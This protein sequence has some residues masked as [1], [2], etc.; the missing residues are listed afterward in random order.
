MYHVF[1]GAKLISL[2]VVIQ[3]DRHKNISNNDAHLNVLVEEST[4]RIQYIFT[5]KLS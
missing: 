1:I 2:R 5:K 3:T 4:Y